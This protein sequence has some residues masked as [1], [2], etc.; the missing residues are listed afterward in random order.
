MYRVRSFCPE[1][2]PPSVSSS[3]RRDLLFPVR[4]KSKKAFE[5]VSLY[6]S[7]LEAARCRLRSTEFWNTFVSLLCESDRIPLI[8]LFV[9]LACSY[10]L[11]S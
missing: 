2:V 1:T 8:S 10:I 6:L 4:W 11:A 5:R 9:G 7:Q 3:L